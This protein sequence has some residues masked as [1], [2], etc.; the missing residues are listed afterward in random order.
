MA[1][2]QP[3]HSVSDVV[4]GRAAS[5]TQVQRRTARSL[6][7]NPQQLQTFH[8]LRAA[9]NLDATEADTARRLAALRVRWQ[10]LLKD[11]RILWAA[12]DVSMQILVA[13]VFVFA[14]GALMLGAL[15]IRAE[16]GIDTF[17]ALKTFLVACGGK[18][19]WLVVVIACLLAEL[20]PK[21]QKCLVVVTCWT[22]CICCSWMVAGCVSD[23]EAF[24]LLLKID[25][26]ISALQYLVFFLA[27]AFYGSTS[28]GHLIFET[29]K[30]TISFLAAPLFIS[31]GYQVLAQVVLNLSGVDPKLLIAS[32]IILFRIL[33]YG[34]KWCL[35]RS[36][37]LALQGSI[38]LCFIFQ[39]LVS[40]T[41][42]R[43]MLKYSGDNFADVI[44]ASAAMNFFEVAGH[45]A[46]S[47]ASLWSYRA[48]MDKLDFAA[49]L[50]HLEITVKTVQC[51]IVAE[52]IALH[53]ALMTTAFAPRALLDLDID[54]ELG[55]A[56]WTWFIQW[57][58]ECLTDGFML[59]MLV[60]FF[61]VDFADKNPRLVLL[62]WMRVCVYAVFSLFPGLQ[63]LIRV[64]AVV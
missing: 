39:L 30:Q 54:I 14:H 63:V 41:I 3:A 38:E 37:R 11:C 8:D 44:I 6:C 10:P 62:S 58:M 43:K 21:L 29:R 16:E 26:A 49:A 24:P 35:K 59:I 55:V 22:S 56:L 47:M 53:A 7:G 45:F 33:E 19:A 64:D 27:L 48:M 12:G 40:Y 36:R 20:A 57:I 34:L 61:P 60:G 51:D 31:L 9:S 5:D 25:P 50:R 1:K 13:T 52:Q 23:V 4:V 18:A 15:A 17:S 32:S 46:S 2:V 42:R 28:S